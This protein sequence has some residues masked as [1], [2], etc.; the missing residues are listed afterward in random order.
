MVKVEAS[1]MIDRPAEGVWNLM[2][3]LSKAPK[4]ASGL[5][6]CRQTSPGLPGVGAILEW[7]HPNVSYSRRVV[8]Y[9]PNRKFTLDYIPEPGKESRYSE[10]VVFLL[11]G[12]EGKTRLTETIEGKVSGFYRLATPFLTRRVRKTVE[13]QVRNVKR[14]LESETK[15]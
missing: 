10:R 8:E 7:K 6:E 13:A 1:V 9:E 5:V 3:D 12:I 11:E 15:S 4:G 2:T 14:I